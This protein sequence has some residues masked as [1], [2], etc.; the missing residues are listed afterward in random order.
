[1]GRAWRSLPG[2]VPASSL[3]LQPAGEQ[4]A[5]VPDS[6]MV[7]ACWLL[8]HK[9]IQTT[10]AVPVQGQEDSVNID[11][12]LVEMKREWASARALHLQLIKL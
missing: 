2:R 10:L 8:S 1:M 3:S 12:R 4:L 9:E 7:T 11:T 6:V 5:P